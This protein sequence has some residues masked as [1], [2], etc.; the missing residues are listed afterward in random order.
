MENVRIG[1]GMRLVA[2]IVDGVI[3]AVLTWV[4]TLVL[5]KIH[6]AL[7]SL[8]GALLGMGYFSLEIFKAQTVGK[9]IFQYKITAQDGSPATREQLVKRFAYKQVPNA[10]GIVAA[11]LMFITPALGF[12]SFIG[13]AAALAIVAGTLL[14]L[15]P[16]KLAYHDKLFGTAVYGPAKVSVSLPN[17][18]DVSPATVSA[19]SA[20]T[21]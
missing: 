2:A 10:I 20:P 6:P 1:F 12:V 17:V 9:M 16:E 5:S 18:S 11:V 19:T 13:L 3:C 14:T 4:P 8:V 15:Q 7:G 21:P